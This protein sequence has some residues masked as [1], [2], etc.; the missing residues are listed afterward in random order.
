MNLLSRAYLVSDDRNK[1]F[2][3]LSLRLAHILRLDRVASAFDTNYACAR[4]LRLKPH[5]PIIAHPRAALKHPAGSHRDCTHLS[6]ECHRGATLC[7]PDVSWR[8]ITERF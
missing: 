1:A 3:P 5:T 4:A 7:R 8:S 2:P 6:R